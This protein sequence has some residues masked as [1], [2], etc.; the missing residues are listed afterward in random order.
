MEDLVWLLGLF[1]GMV[2]TTTLVRW[3]RPKHRPRLRRLFVTFMLYAVAIGATYAFSDN[4]SD[5]GLELGPALVLSTR[6][7]GGLFAL[8]AEAPMTVT[9]KYASGFIFVPKLAASY[10]VPL[11]PQVTAGASC[12]SRSFR[13]SG[14]WSHP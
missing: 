3:I 11:M 8:A 1:V 7:G 6:A 10:E 5:R 9:W 14:S 12:I 2:V 13:S 4:H